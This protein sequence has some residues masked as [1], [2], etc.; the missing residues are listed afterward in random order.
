[1]SAT[2]TGYRFLVICGGT[3]GHLAPGIATA[4]ALRDLG[5]QCLLVVSRKQIDQTLLQKYPE[6][7]FSAIPGAAFSVNP[8]RLAGTLGGHIGNLRESFRLVGRFRPDVILAFGGFLSV[9]AAVVT[10]RRATRLAVHEANRVPGRAVRMLSRIADRVYLP[11]GVR[12]NRV[13]T[14]KIRQFGYPVRS[15]F[16]PIA[17]VAARRR[18]G[19][20]IEGRWVAVIGGSQ[21][22]QSL[23]DW[24]VK[25]FPR[26]AAAG[27]HLILVSGPGKGA[28]S[29]TILEVGEG[30]R[31]RF[32]TMPFCDQMECLLNAADLVVSRAG[33][34]SLA[35]LTRC[36]TPAILIPYRFAA[37]QHQIANARFHEAQGGGI[38]VEEGY[39]GTLLEE[40]LGLAG[41]DWMLAR[42]REN[43]R[44]MDQRNRTAAMVDDLLGLAAAAVEDRL[45][46]K[47]DA[48]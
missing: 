5:C 34:G 9:G 39:L 17:K 10:L 18:L 20:P 12:L 16:G 1:M 44:L 13:P 37:D 30:I 32:R 11:E 3:G 15:E 21:G 27:F 23:N 25:A 35:E 14:G 47:E 40:V 7:E 36:R 38:V 48:A 24:A 2:G 19:I 26:L 45:D 29:E 42:M 28:A 31:R 33:A 6:F 41:N 43:L 4:A 46:R 8:L 22:A